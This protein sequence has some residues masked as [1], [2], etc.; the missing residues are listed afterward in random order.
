MKKI[1][2][3]EILEFVLKNIAK[4]TNNTINKISCDESFF[5]FGY[6]SKDAVLFSGELQ[7]FLGIKLDPTVLFDYPTVNL[8]VEYVLSVY[9][10]N[11][12]TN[13]SKE[14]NI[15]NNEDIAVVGMSCRFPGSS[16][17]EEFLDNLKNGRDL[18]TKIPN[19]RLE[20]L[21]Y[22]N[23]EKYFNNPIFNGGYLNDIELFD[24]DYFNIS[25]EEANNMDPQQRT[26]L[27]EVVKSI[28]DAGITKKI[29]QNEK[30]GIYV[31]VSNNDYSR[32]NLNARS[33]FYSLLGNAQSMLANRVSYL[34]DL[35]G[36]SMTIDTACSSSLVSI[37][38]AAMSIKNNENTIAISAGVNLILD[39]H[40]NEMLDEANMLSI[41]GKC[42]TFDEKANG[43]VRG[44]GV[45]VVVLKK[46]SKAVRDKNHIYAVIKGS[47]INQDGRSIGLTAPNKKMQELLIKEACSNANVDPAYIQY[48]EAHGTGTE[49]GDPIEI[50]AINNVINR[51]RDE[52]SYCK[53]GSI[54]TNIGHLEGASGIAGFI[55]LALSIDNNILFKSLNY[56]SSNPKL[57]LEYKKIQI[58][59]KIQE[60]NND[61]KI[62]GV[63]SFGFGGTNC[64]IILGNNLIN[65]ETRDDRN[66]KSFYLIP[67]S[68]HKKSSLI[69]RLKDIK[70]LINKNENFKMIDLEYTL[71]TRIEPRR[72]RVCYVVK[73]KEE[74]IS[75]IDKTLKNGLD[76]E[77]ARNNKISLIFSGQGTQWVGMARELLK[78]E[79]FNNTFQACRK[80]FIDIGHGDIQEYLFIESKELIMGT[81][82]AQPL[83]FSIEV[84]LAKLLEY[85][86]LDY[87]MAIGHSLGE[88]A[89]AYKVEAI[90]LKTAVKIIHHRSNIM[91]RFTNKGRMLSINK[92]S[93]YVEKLIK[94]VPGISISV[95]NAD[96]SVVVSGNNQNISKFKEYLDS[97]KI[98]NRYLPTNYAFHFIELE[99]YNE[100]LINNLCT[101]KCKPTLK[102][103]ISTV[104][105]D[106]LNTRNLDSNY[107]AR[108][109][110][111]T[112]N[113][114]GAVNAAIN[115]GVNLFV[116]I[117]P[118]SVLLGYIMQKDIDGVKTIASLKRSYDNLKSFYE[119]LGNLYKIGCNINWEKIVADNATLMR[120]PTYKFEE[121]PCWL[122]NNFEPARIKEI[123]LNNDR[124]VKK[125]S[126]EEIK[127]EF[128]EI[129]SNA[130][131][132][133]KYKIDENNSLID[134]GM[135][136]L[137]FIEVKNKVERKFN[138]KL[139]FNEFVV[140]KDISSIITLLN[141]KTNKL[142]ETIKK[143]N[144]I[145]NLEEICDNVT[146][147]QKAII[148]DQYIN[149]ESA[150]YN[151]CAAWYI[152]TE[153]N[154]TIFKKAFDIVVNKYISL[155]LLYK[156][157]DGRIKQFIKDNKNEL[158]IEILGRCDEN[159]LLNKLNKE[160][161]TAFDLSKEVINGT[162][163]VLEDKKVLFINIHH[164][165]IDGISVYILLKHMSR[166][167]ED[168]LSEKVNI[169]END[170]YK[171]LYY[172]LHEKNIKHT[173]EYKEYEDFWK[174]KLEG[175]SLAKNFP[176]DNYQTEASDGKSKYYK[177]KLEKGT[178]DKIRSLA[179]LNRVS[180]FTVLL[181]T[182][183]L[184]Y[185]KLS[186][187]KDFIIGTFFSGRDNNEFQDVIGYTVKPILMRSK[188]E[189]DMNYKE[190]LNN[191][192]RNL[193]DCYE[194]SNISFND[195][196]K[197]LLNVD[198]KIFNH[199]FVYEKTLEE[200]EYPLYINGFN[201]T[202]NLNNISLKSIDLEIEDVQ[203]GLVFMVEE[204]K[205]DLYFSIQYKD[206][207]YS[208]KGIKVILESYLAL[209]NEI[210]SNDTKSVKA[211]KLVDKFN[212]DEINKSLIGE[213]KKFDSK[214]LFHDYLEKY[215]REI[216]KNIAVRYKKI[217]IDYYE[218]NRQ[219]NILARNI[220]KKF[221]KKQ[222]VIG[223]YMEK[224]IETLISIFA[225][226]KAGGAYVPIDNNYP[227]ERIKYIIENS[228]ID[229]LIVNKIDTN[230]LTVDRNIVF[231]LKDIDTNVL[232]ENLN[233][234]IS[235]EDLAYIIYTSGS[236]GRPKGV[237]VS[238]KGIQ[239]VVYEQKKLFNVT[240]S[241]IVSF[242]A[243]IS[244]DASVFDILMAIGHGAI[245]CFD[246]REKMSAGEVLR[247]F[248]I[249]NKIT[250]T[251]VPSSILES[252]DNKELDYLR[253]IVTAGEPCSKMIKDKWAYNHEFYNAYG[254]TEATIWNTTSRCYKEEN[255]C[256]GKSISNTNIYIL[257]NEMNKC[258]IGVKGE[259]YIGGIGLAKGYIGLPGKTKEKFI[260]DPNSNEIIYKTG[261][262][263]KLS[264]K[265]EIEYIGRTDNQIKLRGF[266][267]ELEEIQKV[268]ESNSNVLSSAVILENEK[269]IG[270]V[271]LK[272]ESLD[273][274]ELDKYIKTLLPA[275]MIPN[276]LIKVENWVLTSNGKIDRKAMLSNFKENYEFRKIVK[277]SNKTQEKITELIVPF[278]DNKE[279][280]ME[281]NLIELGFNSI[282]LYEL[283]GRIKNEFDIE[284][285]FKDI[286][287]NTTILGLEKLIKNSVKT[288]NKLLLKP[289]YEKVILTEKQ[290][291][292]WIY[293]KINQKDT[294][295]NIPLVLKI[296]GILDLDNLYKVMKII[297]NRHDVLRTKYYEVDNEVYGE[298][299]EDLNLKFEYI[300][301][302]DK[303]E[304]KARK[305]NST[306]KEMKE[307]IFKL[308][309]YP[310]FKFKVIRYENDVYYL[311]FTIHHMISDGWSMNI[312][313]KEFKEIYVDLL[314]EKEID[315][316]P[317]KYQYQD[318]AY[319]QSLMDREDI[320]S[321]E[322]YWE[323]KFK[324][325]KLIL[326]LPED[327]IRPQIMSN[328]GNSVSIEIK[329]DI[330]KNITRLC[331]KLNITRFSFLITICGVLLRKYTGRNDIIIGTPNFGRENTQVEN[332]I[333]LFIDTTI[334]KL[335]IYD[336]M[337]IEEAI[338]GVSKEIIDSF[339]N[340]EIKLQ[341]IVQLI[342][343]KRDLSRNP[344]FQVMFNMI[345][346]DLHEENIGNLKASVIDN[347]EQDAKFDMTFYAF[348]KANS[349]E[350]KLNY[351]A[352][353]YSKIRMQNILRN[354]VHLLESVVNNHKKKVQEY[355]LPIK[356]DELK[357]LRNKLNYVRD[358]K[359]QQGY[360]ENVKNRAYETAL[361]QGNRKITY[362]K[363][364]EKVEEIK[365]KLI[366]LNLNTGECIA[367]ITSK[368]I[369]L[370]SVM[371]A[372][373]EIGDRFIFI[374]SNYSVRKIKET[375][376]KCDVRTI[377]SVN[378]LSR[379][380]Y[381]SAENIIEFSKEN[382]D[383]IVLKETNNSYSISIDDEEC[384]YLSITSGTTSEP[385]CIKGNNS[386]INHFIKWKIKTY[387]IDFNYR[388]ASFSGI[389]H[390]PFLRDIFTPLMAGGILIFPENPKLIENNLF[391][392]LLKNKINVVNLTP[393]ISEVVLTQA[394][395]DENIVLEDLKLIF[396]GGELLTKTLLKR[397]AKIAPNAKVVNF[398]G[399]TETPQGMAY[400]EYDLKNLDKYK[401]RL[402]IGV[403]IDDVQ[404]L[405]LN[406]NNDILSEGEIGEIA[407]RTKYL[408]KG[409]YK[410]ENLTNEKFIRNKYLEDMNDL[411]YK[412]GDNGRYNLDGTIEFIGRMD[413]QVKITG[414]R[415]ELSE[416]ECIL[417]EYTSIR[418]SKVLV[419][420][421]EIYAF[422]IVR[423]DFKQDQLNNYISENLNAYMIPRKV[424][425]LKEIPVNNNG[426]INNKKLI[427][428][429]KEDCSKKSIKDNLLTDT[430]KKIMNVWNEILGSETIDPE[431]K[432]FE[433][434][435]NSL[436]AIKLQSKLYNLYGYKVTIVDIFK[437]PT[438]KGLAIYIDKSVKENDTNHGNRG[439]KIRSAIINNKKRK[440]N[441]SE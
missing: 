138:V 312:L 83:I 383:V 349:I 409:Y 380:L 117:A 182:Y 354:Y 324:D 432:F 248:Y 99:K 249:N 178:V 199:V 278:I 135:D 196:Y 406:S 311:L 299:L 410:N 239:N 113:F 155:K 304:E 279:I 263:V 86:G 27:Q 212:E 184:L 425:V 7:E 376:K 302:N 187:E 70:S 228:N 165:A 310:L 270:M 20:L 437:Y 377:I 40:V 288:N 361:M 333:G 231:D 156:Y 308:D 34:L 1:S 153:I 353:V 23:K 368:D 269:L 433:V 266:R 163:Y 144:E 93:A 161:N 235:E 45:G 339:D 111:K 95:I 346:F 141:E 314:E 77:E 350:I 359:L 412:T 321:K 214:M 336:Y 426:K 382:M 52:K 261:D 122:N 6:D 167:Y 118:S 62:G 357:N 46:L 49:L 341:K 197:N 143:D 114:N 157:E 332:L 375:I 215:A 208:E 106:I 112:V 297:L 37:H 407:I 293:N 330:Y 128:I 202:L 436:K 142:H 100:E 38:E 82:V 256:I 344:I 79:K 39:L 424:F 126:R 11:N 69:S 26:L 211:Y 130:L 298:I 391:E 110:S 277:A 237:Q 360:E 172:Q 121:K 428:I 295:Y 227:Q 16:S 393:S 265:G 132:I 4:K 41:D 389:S 396:T 326:E 271:K 18:V 369:D 91:D 44:E 190:F 147:G 285:K 395:L 317:L 345:N 400:M 218:L 12:E 154:E 51:G 207:I 90:S 405:I 160:A 318:Y 181:S 416:I 397:I 136:S 313:L 402:P 2:K 63:S 352:D 131:N 168:I 252:M 134:I 315:M 420:E 17:I 358:I 96:N 386:A 250:I 379:E 19:E 204:C 384:G 84:S 54:K 25:Q 283:I 268:I 194:N 55:K 441:R 28:E 191:S 335:N 180:L 221:S 57:E 365:E 149:S 413:E 307:N 94:N 103:Y 398:Y 367:I 174:N 206:N 139:K 264:Y 404:M 188:I 104:T 385:K 230:N 158:N 342:N 260:K 362:K 87:E 247:E 120:I 325:T 137:K 125:V 5:Y 151:M 72:Y 9:E 371:L 123:V 254:V 275:Y 411:I 434:G 67:I 388:F 170:D 65:R 282:M 303:I 47:S 251:T 322:K 81:Y 43:Y 80:E 255:V 76:I 225:I 430:E 287:M 124:I 146:E 305:L 319:T 24:F 30:I 253:I 378:S 33:G 107:W 92:N 66:N 438:V 347:N 195:L 370:I 171:Y 224:S 284:L 108:N 36:V 296:K 348:E 53:V 320:I 59:D 355:L 213:K 233:L 219:S 246:E 50:G 291:G 162:L 262:L 164:V 327:Y 32:L 89:A 64:H 29:I 189:S 286:M 356:N 102:K 439:N 220:L 145:I 169:D 414:H 421:N 292:L 373:I 276:Y 88:I 429:I 58:Q 242:F 210:I 75:K 258:P 13:G 35:K 334:L 133:D 109:M 309:E 328:N 241:D 331:N 301:L 351:Y 238:H 71:A 31:G 152:T 3:S 343:P 273:I 183:E 148:I 173:D 222:L 73:D 229:G 14:N 338:E 60:W 423:N 129:I 8:L 415:V 294:S 390:D 185:H 127:E 85:Y 374:D 419:Y 177:F 78:F 22:E 201:S 403:G 257:N 198:N 98:S 116:E 115:R 166:L 105:G 101:I 245:L 21:C 387:G 205:D 372:V 340:K 300:D 259:M 316:E 68:A 193:L 119:T 56:E 203:Y 217:E 175:S 290:K 236:T 280:S 150:M 209:V 244:F 61:T 48:V 140:A 337:N 179:K 223:I 74:L 427:E 232:G 267:I 281:D 176:I 159:E 329:D 186:G 401:E 306:I 323:D 243:S 408:S 216:P 366:E 431:D 422:A 381:K 363:L 192:H 274:Q 417:N 440:L 435:G 418:S 289:K 200:S 234:E 399:A 272:D 240:S 15:Y 42:H 392:F 226:M 10:N 394:P 97:N 364:K